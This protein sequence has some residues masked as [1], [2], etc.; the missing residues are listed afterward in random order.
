MNRQT[1]ARV[2]GALFVI[3]DVAGIGGKVLL[4]RE[5]DA[6]AVITGAVLVFVM[7]LA[8]AMIPVA[9]FPVLKK[10]NEALALGYAV[11]RV[12]EALLLTASAVAPLLVLTVGRQPATTQPGLQP[13][14]GALSMDEYWAG[15]FGQI[16]WSLSVMVLL[17]LLH[18]SR[19][20]PRYISVWGLAGAPLYLASQLLILYGVAGPLATIVTAQFGINELVLVIW[21]LVRGLRPAPAATVAVA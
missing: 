1:A 12:I 14:A 2:A 6:N 11:L 15:P 3:A 4:D 9:L 5:N 19:A 21:L 13:V 7:A 10:Q 20:V 18:R 8:V 17:Y 16:A